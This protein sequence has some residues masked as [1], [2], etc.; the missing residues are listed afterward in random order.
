MSFVPVAVIVSPAAPVTVRL[1]PLTITP[2]F[3]VISLS[4][5]PA[6]SVSLS[7][8]PLLRSRHHPARAG[9]RQLPL[10]VAEVIDPQ[11]CHGAR[12]GSRLSG[13]GDAHRRAGAQR[14]LVGVAEHRRGVAGRAV[15]GVARPG[16]RGRAVDAER[17]PAA[18]YAD[19]LLD[20]GGARCPTPV[21]KMSRYWCC[22]L[23]GSSVACHAG[24]GYRSLRRSRPCC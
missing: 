11:R 17:Y 20:A 16:D 18:R 1:L 24:D 13:A 23:D 10:I 19:R 22:Q 2:A 6:P 4:V 7:A 9:S 12:C 5:L 8:M 15:D 21:P 14:H 3:A